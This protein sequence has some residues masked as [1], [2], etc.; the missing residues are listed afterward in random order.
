[1]KLEWKSYLEN[2]GAEFNDINTVTSFGNPTRETKIVFTGDVISVLSH[3]G[4]ISVYGDD[5]EAFLQGQSTNDVRNVNENTSQLSAFCNQK[6]RVITNFRL[7]KCKDTYYLRLPIDMIEDTLRRLKIYVLR[8]KVTLE[9]ATNNFASI[10][11]AGPN[12]ES[13][14]TNLKLDTPE[15]IDEVTTNNDLCIIKIPG[16]HPRFEIY[17]DLDS[18]KKLW[19]GLDVRAAP[20]GTSPWQLLDIHS[21]IVTIRPETAEQFVP[22]MLNLQ[23]I[24]SVSFKK[25]CFT[26]QEIVARMQYLGKL[27]RRM[28]RAHCGKDIK[29]NPGE[30]LFST[31]SN[32]QQACGEI[33]NSQPATDGGYDLLA[34]VDTKS[35]EKN[36]IHISSIEGPEIIF[37][38]LPYAFEEKEDSTAKEES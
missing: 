9:N 5:A 4:L 12:T 8:A 16:P 22:Q 13:E 11:Y 19:S 7:F 24:N 28:Y 33:I 10:G 20:I 38:T 27:K 34:V 15:N 35:F 29:P 26:G 23:L 6:G 31:S 2:V 3:Y 30:K 25:G 1:M 17:G 14:L 37:D 18:I 36:D 21:G 32:N